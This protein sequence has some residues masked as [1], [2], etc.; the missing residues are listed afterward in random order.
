[1]QAKGRRLRV[2]QS[3][4]VLSDSSSHLPHVDLIVSQFSNLTVRKQTLKIKGVF[5]VKPAADEQIKTHELSRCFTH[6]IH[7]KWIKSK[8]LQFHRWFHALCFRDVFIL[9]VSR[10]KT[11]QTL[12]YVTILPGVSSPR[13]INS[14]FVVVFTTCNTLIKVWEC[15]K[16]KP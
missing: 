10:V 14:L 11:R 1:M 4:F 7:L 8:M 2:S 13:G 16:V 15:F 6:R 9:W 5:L 3:Q 12:P